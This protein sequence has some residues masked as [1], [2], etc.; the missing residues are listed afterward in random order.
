MT[1]P[2]IF[3]RYL[4][5]T[6]WLDKVEEGRFTLHIGNLY[7][8][9]LRVAITIAG[10]EATRTQSCVVG[11]GATLHIKNLASGE[12]VS[13]AGPGNDPVILTVE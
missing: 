5:V 8:Q 11:A 6:T 4:P 7:L 2:T 3:A 9:P 10:P 12:R 13:I 1:F